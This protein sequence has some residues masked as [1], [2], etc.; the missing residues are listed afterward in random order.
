MAE[1]EQ[2]D[3]IQDT[4]LVVGDDEGVLAND[5][6]E[7]LDLPQV[8]LLRTSEGGQIY[9]DTDGSYT[10][11]SAPGFSGT[12]TVEYTTE[13]AGAGTLTINVTATALLP[14]VS[15]GTQLSERL[16]IIHGFGQVGNGVVTSA[17]SPVALSGGGY[18]VQTGYLEQAFGSIRELRTYDADHNLLSVFDPGQPIVNQAIA[19]LPGGGYVLA[20]G[21][22]DDSAGTQTNPVQLFDANGTSVSGPTPFD[23]PG[24]LD[25]ISDLAALPDG[26]FVLLQLSVD[27]DNAQLFAQSFSATGVPESQ[28]YAVG[29]D[30]E[31]RNPFI[32][33]NGQIVTNRIEND[34]ELYLQR[35]DTHGNPIGAQ[36]HPLNGPDGIQ[37]T[38]R[39]EPLAGGGFAV[40]WAANYQ[41]DPN[42]PEVGVKLYTQVVDANGNLVGTSNERDFGFSPLFG[43]PFGTITPLA[44]G[45]LVVHARGTE[46]GGQ[47][48][49]VVQTYDANG[50]PVG[51]Q[52][53]FQSQTAFGTTRALVFALPEGGFAIGLQAANEPDHEYLLIYDNNGS[54]V[55]EVRM[56]DIGDGTGASSFVLTNLAGGDTLIVG[57][58][59]S[60]DD[61][62]ENDIW[63]QTI[64]FDTPT[65]VIQADQIGGATPYSAVVLP[66]RVSIP[67]DAD[68]SEIVQS[69]VISGVPAGWT[70]SLSNATAT[71]NAG[72]WTVTGPGIAKG[73][74]IDLHLTAPAGTPGSGT[75]SVVA[76]TLDTDNGSQNQSFPASFDFANLP[77]LHPTIISNGGGDG[78]AVQ[79]AENLAAVTTVVA[80]DLDNPPTYAIAGGT[81]A[82]LFAINTATGA[83]TFKTAPD[84][85]APEDAG[86]D[87]VYEVIVAAAYGSVADTQTILVT[88]SDIDGVTITG[89]KGKD[90]VN[91]TKSAKGQPL[92]TGEEDVINGRGGNDKLSGLGGDD[93]ISGGAGKD[94]VKGGAG[95]DT[96]SGG[97]GPDKLVGGDGLDSYVLD[98][99]IALNIFN[100]FDAAR[101]K[102][103][104]DKIAD[105][106]KGETIVLDAD[107]FQGLGKGPLAAKY[108][109]IGNKAETTHQQ[110][111]YDKAKGFLLHDW[112]GSAAGGEAFLA[113]I[114]KNIGHLDH[115]D[116]MVA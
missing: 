81:D 98:E 21:V 68:G 57:Q 61:P 101:L 8:Q 32:L 75:L 2:I 1:N 90:K 25:R 24:P 96:I 17:F 106:E 73:G 16:P 28:R 87:N 54:L 52:I 35:Y 19:A 111:L 63:V 10:Y 62:Q 86:G 18:V 108:F 36:I 67:A 6:G 23:V 116:I 40:T 83:L 27:G 55:G 71:L 92:P 95:D 39:V 59:F 100:F 88:V 74:A 72:V 56:H 114:G 107:V 105:Y 38:I 65:P 26:G 80:T 22:R 14:F 113:K 93:S 103:R 69:L 20:Y 7:T 46:V 33:P 97:A 91:A 79:V 3:A 31:L 78:A 45:G 47:L 51:A 77:A 60:N 76:H 37:S 110:I 11:I 102:K 42:E 109:G 34:N 94:V 30:A 13:N 89:T 44:N 115:T 84:F 12:D 70:L 5:P 43:A 49:D 66:V 29:G 99:R 58:S 9:F 15:I 64:R 4:T 50:N 82:A 48:V 41:I 112:N 53:E 85:E 104:V